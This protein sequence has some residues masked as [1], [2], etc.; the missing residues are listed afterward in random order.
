MYLPNRNRQ[1]VQ[2]IQYLSSCFLAGI[3]PAP[4]RVDGEEGEQSA[5]ELDP[6]Q[7]AAKLRPQVGLETEDRLTL[8]VERLLE[9]WGDATHTKCAYICIYIVTTSHVINHHT[10]N[11]HVSSPEGE[12]D[13]TGNPSVPDLTALSYRAVTRVIKVAG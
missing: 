7:E 6:R 13:K 1:H 2:Y 11:G 5:I 12:K 4:W 3:P 8:F 10:N 9:D